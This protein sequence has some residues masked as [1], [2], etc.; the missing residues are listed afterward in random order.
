MR[1]VWNVRL[2]SMRPLPDYRCARIA[3][4]ASLAPRSDRVAPVRSD[5]RVPGHVEASSHD[6][7]GGRLSELEDEAEN[8][9]QGIIEIVRIIGLRGVFVF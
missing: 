8:V 5:A 9:E 4:R 7:G 1:R 3:W 6:R 2:G